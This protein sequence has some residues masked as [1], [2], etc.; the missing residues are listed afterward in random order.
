MSNNK[1][2]DRRDNAAKIKENIKSTKVQMEAADEMIAMTSDDKTKK[3]L[4]EKNERRQ[5]ALIGMAKELEDEN[6]HSKVSHE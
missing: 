4:Q 3:D 5:E 1:P 6:H 2:D